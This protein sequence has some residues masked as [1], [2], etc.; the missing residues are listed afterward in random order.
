[1]VGAGAAVAGV[2]GGTVV[3]STAPPEEATAVAFLGVDV[4]PLALDPD[5][6][7]AVRTPAVRTT[8][9]AATRGRASGTA[10]HAN[11]SPP[12]CEIGPTG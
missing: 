10:G 7:H 11:P 6:E 3:A 12:L 4:A 5:E 2:V 8:A 1:L 9:S